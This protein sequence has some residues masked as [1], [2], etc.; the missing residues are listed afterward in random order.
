MKIYVGNL[1][2]ATTEEELRKT[3]ATYG[4]PESVKI[5]KDESSGQS[6]GFG[7]IKLSNAAQAQE[8]ITGLNG[9][10]LGGNTLTAHEA[11][12]MA[13]DPSANLG[14]RWQAAFGGLEAAP[15]PRSARCPRAE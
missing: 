15:S 2:P 5:I 8:A 3:F 12:A 13:M 4:H 7:F 6:R 10:E 14:K 9:S 11:R 1:S